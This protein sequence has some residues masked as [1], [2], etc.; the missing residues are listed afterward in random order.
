MAKT[1]VESLPYASVL[2]Y[3]TNS[4]K[5]YR[6]LVSLYMLGSLYKSGQFSQNEL[7][8]FAAEL[9]QQ[10]KE[11]GKA[12]GPFVSSSM[13]SEAIGGLASILKEVAKKTK[14]KIVI[15]IAES[16]LKILNEVAY[17]TYESSGGNAKEFAISTLPAAQI[18]EAVEY[19]VQTAL[20]TEGFA[21]VVDAFNVGLGIVNVSVLEDPSSVIS[22]NPEVFE[23]D[24]LPEK[25]VSILQKLKE[26]G[27]LLSEDQLGEIETALEKIYEETADV[28]ATVQA[29]TDKLSAAV[30]AALKNE[31]SAEKKLEQLEYATKE[32]EAAGFIFT[33][34]LGFSNPVLAAKLS[35]VINATASAVRITSQFLANVAT[36]G[37]IAVAAGWVGVIVAVVSLFAASDD[38]NDTQVLLDAIAQV[39]KQIVELHETLVDATEAVLTELQVVTMHIDGKFKQILL[40]NDKII[41]LSKMSLEEI[42]T[43]KATLWDHG[44][45]TSRL[46]SSLI[47]MS[48]LILKEVLLNDLTYWFTAKA[49]GAGGALT[50]QTFDVAMSRLVRYATDV[51]VE[52]TNALPASP[53]NN[54]VRLLAEVC[55][56]LGL[57]DH[58]T[59]FPL[60]SGW[61]TVPNPLYWTYGVQLYLA[62]MRLYPE[63]VVPGIDDGPKRNVVVDIRELSAAG[64]RISDY[65]S[66]FGSKDASLSTSALEQL[67]EHLKGQWDLLVRDIADASQKKAM[68]LHHGFFPWDIEGSLASELGYREADQAIADIYQNG[69]P[70][71]DGDYASQVGP[72][73]E[74]KPIDGLSRF[75]RP[76][77]AY[78][79]ASGE[80]GWTCSARLVLMRYFGGDKVVE[81]LPG[82]NVIGEDIEIFPDVW[83]Q[84][85]RPHAETKAPFVT[86]GPLALDLSFESLKPLH[87]LGT[88][89]PREGSKAYPT[90]AGPS[91]IDGLDS[92]VT[93][94]CFDI[95]SFEPF[96]PP[97]SLAEY[98][99]NLEAD[100]EASRIYLRVVN[101]QIIGELFVKSVVKPDGFWLNIAESIW[102]KPTYKFSQ[103][104]I[105]IANNVASNW[106]AAAHSAGWWVKGLG[107]PKYQT[108]YAEIYRKKID[109][110][111]VEIEETIVYSVK[112]F[113]VSDLSTDIGKEG[114][115][116]NEIERLSNVAWATRYVADSSLRTWINQTHDHGD[117]VIVLTIDTKVKWIP[118]V[119]WQMLQLMET[120]VLTPGKLDDLAKLEEQECKK[121]SS[122][123]EEKVCRIELPVTSSTKSD[124]LWRPSAVLLDKG[125]E[126]KERILLE[127][128]QMIS[129]SGAD[130]F[131]RF[132]LRSQIDGLESTLKALRDTTEQEPKITYDPAANTSELVAALL[133]ALQSEAKMI[134]ELKPS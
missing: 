117:N 28:S 119:Q 39:S 20:D 90:G 99:S 55:R 113:I 6:P 59:G 65:L 128:G 105:D 79:L 36:V 129:R 116:A 111:H 120:S 97:G 31:D 87:L 86:T 131:D 124:L 23:S 85:N 88:T 19:I 22:K 83:I 69:N 67:L 101:N 81:K 58:E 103:T 15:Q 106:W 94:K 118:H 14:I 17:K 61:A 93:V 104:R 70:G 132:F 38:G 5:N 92:G 114:L 43:L 50:P 8:G 123:S 72:F 18:K 78:R 51:A 40:K 66:E 4:G 29:L 108:E 62:L 54:P 10:Q 82:F 57:I 133:S 45:E 73:R 52:A 26:E 42:D 34:I 75:L 77:D 84:L 21:K 30:T 16:G 25:V 115:F 11:L 89:N 41:Q 13:V 47:A 9:I 7:D 12:T 107:M 27:A 127:L 121:V 56:D 71:D 35:E 112:Q 95:I 109:K 80:P 91:I 100:M 134:S 122:F 76:I 37:P 53:D 49:I 126:S 98:L 32:F 110:G 60:G 74:Q 46:L 64:T 3:E 96:M 44:L 68:N 130:A 1:K 2:Y 48:E 125:Q 24:A 102:P 33:S 63:Y